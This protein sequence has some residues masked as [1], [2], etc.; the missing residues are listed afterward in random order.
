M[1]VYLPGI[2]GEIKSTT[3]ICDSKWHYIAM[4]YEKQ[5]VKLFVDGKKVKEQPINYRKHADTTEGFAIGSL[6]EKTIGCDGAIDEL[7]LS[8]E[9]KII[10]RVPTQPF[11][12]E[13]TTIG[14][15]R[16]DR[17]QDK[18]YLDQS[19]HKNHL[20]RQWDP[21]SGKPVIKTNTQEPAKIT[22]HWGEDAIGFRWTEK[23]S[24]DNR[25]AFTQHGRFLASTIPLPGGFAEKGLVI[26]IG[27]QEEASVCYD[28]KQLN[29]MAAWSGGFLEFHEA[30]FG[31]I[32]HLKPVGSMIFHNQG[33][34]GW[35]LPDV[36]YRGLYN[37]G[38]RTVLEY[39]VG[40]TR[41]FESPWLEKKGKVFATTREFHI[42]PIPS[43]IQVPI[44][45]FPMMKN[46]SR[47]TIGNSE[48]VAFEI[49]S[50][51]IAA[52]VVSDHPRHRIFAKNN[53]L[54]LALG[55]SDQHTNAKVLIGRAPQSNILEFESL[56]ASSNDSEI[57]PLIQPGKKNWTE[58][59]TTSGVLSEQTGWGYTVD[60]IR[61]PF[62]NPYGSLFFVSGHDWL[63][64]GDM[65]VATVHGEVWLAK[66]VNSDLRK[67][68]WKRYATGLY[69]P[70]GI[71]VVNNRPHVLC[72]DQIVR[73]HDRDQNDEADYYE[74]FHADVTT[75]TGVHDYVCC[76]ET[77][78]QGN[79][80]Y[81]HANDGVV[82]V[83]PDGQT[84]TIIA[85]GFR[86]PNGMGVR[87]DGLVTAAPQEGEWTPAS[88]VCEVIEGKH[89]GYRGPKPKT[90][91]SPL[92]YE[93]PLVFLPR[94][95][96]N[97]SGGQF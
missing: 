68:T 93:K 88:G 46:P 91:D 32:R 77:D 2:F 6:V 81:I 90:G 33:G 79:F 39:F 83:S 52:A 17:I 96:D 30:R 85:T 27:E 76:L 10:D 67:I 18:N 69:Q 48:M 95:V 16:F 86:N 21:I 71:R 41:V 53:Q 3:D 15:W 24:Q 25:W 82:R 56:I 78:A 89:Y 19:K 65:V 1:S 55:P 62:Q 84:K 8:N 44:S 74:C 23:D 73:L 20:T 80:Y 47:K 49:E 42:G 97:S 26:K 31:L 14:L 63:D 94:L 4:T 87:A 36:Q 5:F 54:W 9:L 58:E 38:S 72:R 28:L 7:R 59:I 37:H 35:N 45:S 29:L 70:L 66:N 51:F 40:K 50:D 22:G 13:D 12:V 64:N 11:E 60:T 92:G 43:E 34:S 75:S 57:K 61:L